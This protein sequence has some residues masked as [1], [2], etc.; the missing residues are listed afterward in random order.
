MNVKN[1]EECVNASVENLNSLDSVEAFLAFC[2]KG[3]MYLLSS[4]NLFAVYSQ[5]PDATFVSSFS[6][7]KELKRYPKKHTGIAVYPFNTSGVYGNFTDYVFEYTDTMGD[8]NVRVWTPTEELVNAY[9]ELKKQNKPGK[10]AFSRY[11][12][13]QF[14][15][16]AVVDIGNDN[17][18][19]S[20]VSAQNSEY[21]LEKRLHLHFFIAEM[22]LK[23]FSERCGIPYTLSVDFKKTFER[24]ICPDGK[25]NTSLFME[26]FHISLNAIRGEFGVLSSFIVNEKRRIRNERLS[27]AVGAGR[28][29]GNS[30]NRGESAGE[31]G[32]N[33]RGRSTGRPGNGAGADLSGI[34]GNASETLSPGKES[35]RL[36]EGKLSGADPDSSGNEP[37]GESSRS[38][39]RRSEGDVRKSSFEVPENG[40][41]STDGNNAEDSDR[42]SNSSNDLGTDQPG[43]SLS[44]VSILSNEQIDIFSYLS[45]KE[46]DNLTVDAIALSEEDMIE[47]SGYRASS[48]PF[49]D[50]IIDSILQYGPSGNS[51]Y[52]REDIFNYISTTWYNNNQEEQLAYLK[53][54]FKNTSLGFEFD[55]RKVSSYYDTEK[56]LLLSYGEECRNHPLMTIAWEEVS[57]R[58]DALVRNNNFMDFG[59]EK[60]ASDIDRDEL[61]KELYF[62]FRD[63]FELEKEDIPEEFRGSFGDDEDNFK[64]VFDDTERMRELYDVVLSLYEKGQRGELAVKWKYVD[65]L[66]TA[67]HLKRFLNGRHSFDLPDTISLHLPTFIPMDMFDMYSGITSKSKS[68]SN[69]LFRF[70]LYEASEGGTNVT[71]A[72]KYLSNHYGIGGIGFSNT[73]VEHMNNKGFE[74]TIRTPEHTDVKSS[75]SYNRIAKRACNYIKQDKFFMEGEKEQYPIWKQNKNELTNTADVFEKELEE[76]ANLFREAAGNPYATLPSLSAGDFSAVL[77]EIGKKVFFGSRFAGVKARLFTLY[78]SNKLTHIDKENLTYELFSVNKDKIIHLTGYD[79]ARFGANYIISTRYPQAL[80]IRCFPANYIDNSAFLNSSNHFSVSVEQLSGIAVSLFSSL[81]E[82]E[83]L[84][85]FNEDN[86]INVNHTETSFYSD[87]CD[88]YSNITHTPEEINDAKESFVGY[89]VDDVISA[90]YI[91]ID[92]SAEEQIQTNNDENEINHNEDDSLKSDASNSLDD[93]EASPS[94]DFTKGGAYP[95][96]EFHYNK[97]WKANVGSDIERFRKNLAA[98]RTL[99]QIESEN[100]Y[101]TASE[102]VVLSQYVGWGGLSSFF[103]TVR[104]DNYSADR[105]ELK[106]LLTEEEYNSAKSTVTD[107]FYTPREVL[108]GVYKALNEMGFNGGNVLDPAM[109][110]GNFYNAMPS[111]MLGNSTLY[112]VEID[113][114]S[115]RIAK[116]LHPECNIQISGIESADLPDSFFD[117]VIGNVPF[118]D[119]KVDDRKF[120]KMNLMIHDYFF[121]KALDLCAPGGIICFITSKGTLDKKNS[122]VREYI[123]ERADFL[124]AIRLPNVAF[125][126]SANTEVT[127]DI[128][129][130]QKKEVNRLDNQEFVSVEYYNGIPLNS[131]FVTNP[132]MMLGEMRV[133]TAR[134]GPDRALSFLEAFPDFD[135]EADLSG[136]VSY[137]P[138]NVFTGTVKE[139]NVLSAA[140]GGGSI[141]ADS[142]VKN[143][144]Y[145]IIDGSVYMR[146][147]SRLVLKDGYNSRQKERITGLCGIR[148]IMHELIN[149]QLEGHPEAVIKECQD[150]LNTAYDVFVEKNGFINEKENKRAFCDDVEYTLLCAL[151]NPTETSYEKAQIFTKQ[152]IFPRIKRSHTDTAL[153]ALNITV[154]DYG[155][156]NIEN[157]MSLYDCTFDDLLSELKGEIYLNP[158]KADPDNPY[159]GYETSEEYLSGDVRKKLASAKIAV[160]SDSR[161]QENV[162][163]LTKVIPADLD[164]NDIEVK[165]GS[166]WI[167]PEDYQEFMYETFN[168]HGWTQGICYLEY[169]SYVNS[170]FIQQKSSVRTV[171]NT[172]GFGT[173]RMSALEI[174][175]NLLNLRQ[176]TVKDRIDAG[177]GKYSYVVNQNETML[178]RAKAEQI[179]DTFKEWIFADK[180]RREKYVRIYNDNF[181]NIRIREYDG[182][183][184]D[185]P[186]MN[187]EYELR[188]HQKNAIARIIRGGNTLLGHCVGAGKSF[189]MAAACM[190]LKRLG[191]A[192]KPMIVVPNH[193]TGQMANEFLTLY[194]S[195][196]VLLTTKKDFEKNNRKRFISK[197]ATGEYDAVIIGH[198]QFEKIPISTERQKAFFERE[199]AEIQGFISKL[200]FERNQGWSVKQMEAQKKKLT[201][202]FNI[203]ANTDYK[204]DVITFEE[205]GVDCLMIDE[206]HNYKNLSFNTKMGNVAGINPNGSNKAFD[207][208]QKVQ[209]INELSPGRNVIFATGT[210]VSNTMCEMYLMQKYLQSDMLREKGIYHFD[211]W[212]ANYGETVTAMELAPEGKGYREKTRFSRFTNLPELITSFRMVADIQSQ[213]ALSYLDI[214]TMA[215][216]KAEIIESEPSDD[217]LECVQ[218]FCERAKAVRDG[219]VDPSE[220]NMLK[221]CHDAKLVST[222]I[223]MLFP[224]KDPDYQSKLY[225]CIDNVY[226][227][228]KEYDADKAS[229]VIFSDIGV[230]NSNGGFNVYQFIKA[231]LVEKGVPAEEI[232]FIHDAKNEKERSDMFQ[233]IRSGAKRVII[234]STEKMGTGTN[235]QERLIALHEIDV[236][237][238]PSDVEQREGRILRQGNMYDKVHVLRYVTKRTFDAYNW[239]IIENKQ[240]FISQIMSDGSLSR[241]CEDIDEVVFNYGEMVACAS[242]NPLIK[243][244]MEIDSEVTKLQLLKRSFLKNRYKLEKDFLEVLPNRKDRLTDKIE[245]LREDIA[246]RN[247]SKL[248]KLLHASGEDMQEVLPDF[249]DIGEEKAAAMDKTDFIMTFNGKEITERKTAGE[250]ILNMFKKVDIGDKNVNFAEFAG[251]TVG[252][253]KKNTFLGV[254]PVIILKGAATYEIPGS[255]SS[256]IGNAMRIQ[257][258]VRGFETKLMEYE[259]RLGEVEE[260]IAASKVEYEKGFPKEEALNK[261]LLRQVELTELLAIKDEPEDTN[262]DDT[263]NTVSFSGEGIRKAL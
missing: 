173:S 13:E 247:D 200:K 215:G 140:A 160:L 55:G 261:A 98:I 121:A 105:N 240:K 18:R 10:D 16:A 250:L 237:W 27:G 143:F 68:E 117:C 216:D 102:Q 64:T 50:E 67:G 106:H 75:L 70:E 66:G 87:I 170:Y 108:G 234:G 33:D 156:V 42:E 217:I 79:Y 203:L 135:M 80:N 34:R 147:N 91:R 227:I 255:I 100:R 84:A 5:R 4:E 74:I 149:V 23:I 183:F 168:I 166:N 7:W 37:D 192:N 174:Y 178:A 59:G 38:E 233:D 109:G 167:T 115:G 198:S 252:V 208:F 107:S 72:A 36:S 86:H 113:N 137:L 129:F 159:T 77:H 185:F 40:E 194:P 1:L 127:S 241:N 73:S 235:I 93:A 259:E 112:G 45:Q 202:K 28:G 44:S 31:S 220:D 263:D 258:C 94:F 139:E 243:E 245:K 138:K 101:A 26:C 85:L 142:S 11:F 82:E 232:C 212:A 175:E 248:F 51:R 41:R 207:L 3:N 228:Y 134:F 254:D 39:N 103:E 155:Y 110:I 12:L 188:P 119:Y 24:D 25:L 30:T 226:R 122:S 256:A 88:T 60:R 32:D 130:L 190:E 244:K 193:L 61:F 52:G 161:Y 6:G 186:G 172:N 231:G 187:P 219:E 78:S 20:F 158:E 63:G 199:I 81:S 236:P 239:S 99:K 153:E 15:T 163:V 22:S 249:K 204:D 136:V 150:R 214:P 201:A 206:A 182:S 111:E 124:G 46:D 126:G 196:N 56:G 242:G 246:T 179:K 165:L 251:F 71:A 209:Y 230:P 83:S 49:S 223:R 262:T 257:N 69:V 152:T 162:D 57:N 224:E 65:R 47:Q 260:A 141:P 180:D 225:K 171:E 146:E 211:A 181:N 144:T 184:L 54:S 132:H 43:N 58:L 221:I 2:S 9:F 120:N 116:L 123:S 89:S 76:E 21:T 48:Q 19:L 17:S 218:W 213:S 164:A 104:T 157:I 131:Y 189:E 125:K 14:H 154:A 145:K 210:P 128:I 62:F 114:I 92:S 53:K 169:N 96:V 253:C 8:K 195:A 151:E 29:N 238:R 176:I 177:D 229:Q 222:D 191:L 95:P 35:S 205:L 118:G 197:I 148:D 90:N 133:D 97:D